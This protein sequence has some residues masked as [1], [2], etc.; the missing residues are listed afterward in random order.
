MSNFL[1][2]LP[3]VRHVRYFYLRARFNAWWHSVGRHL[4]AVP[5]ESDIEYL[6]RVWRGES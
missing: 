1:G 2:R 3:G 4:G 5:N 6:D